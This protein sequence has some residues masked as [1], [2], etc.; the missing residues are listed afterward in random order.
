MNFLNKTG[1]TYLIEKIKST[2]ITKAEVLVMINKEVETTNIIADQG[3]IGGMLVK[4]VGNQT[5]IS[6]A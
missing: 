2:M 3:I 4:K 6:G 1:L 5:W